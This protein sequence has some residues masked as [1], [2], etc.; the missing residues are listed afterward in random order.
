MVSRGFALSSRTVTPRH[1]AARPNRPP[2]TPRPIGSVP[3]SP[4]AT[5]SWYPTHVIRRG[6]DRPSEPKHGSTAERAAGRAAAPAAVGLPAPDA[7]LHP[8]RARLLVPR[9]LDGRQRIIELRCGHTASRPASRRS[10]HSVQVQVRVGER[11][12]S[13]RVHR[14]SC[15]DGDRVSEHVLYSIIPRRTASTGTSPP[16]PPLQLGVEMG[17]QLN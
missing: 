6:R 5:R 1:R 17:A 12:T 16:A 11:V 15:H 9:A 14:H 3:H 13:T 4:A 8:A 10:T 7:A 2:P